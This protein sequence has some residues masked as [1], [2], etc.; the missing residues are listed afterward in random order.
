MGKKRAGFALASTYVQLLDG[1][2]AETVDVDENFWSE[3]DARKSLHRGRLVG[4]MRMERGEGDHSEVHPAGD[5]LLILISGAADVVL[6]ERGGERAIPLT[7]GQA[8]VVPR[9]TWHH[10]RVRRAGELV[11]VTP[12]RGTR[13][14]ER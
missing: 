7:A 2:R 5:E 11:F 8:C 14:R 6:E 4:L 12:G 1:L 3:I 9:G 10:F 13:A